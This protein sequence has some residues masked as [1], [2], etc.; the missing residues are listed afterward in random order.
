M[1]RRIE[2]D[3]IRTVV[4]FNL[5]PFHAAFLITATPGFSQ[6]PETSNVAKILL[7]YL[8]LIAP[9]HMPLLFIIAGYSLTASVEKRSSL[10]SHLYE[11]IQRLLVPLLVFMTIF[12]PLIVY[13][14]PIYQGERSFSHYFFKFWP[15]ILSRLFYNEFTEGPGWAHLW[16]VGYLMLMTLIILPALHYRNSERVKHLSSLITNLLCSP[17]GMFFPALLFGFCFM[18]LALIWP[19]YQVNLYSDWAYFC[20]NFIAFFIGCFMFGKEKFLDLIEKYRFLWLFLFLVST[21]AKLNFASFADSYIPERTSPELSFIYSIYSFSSGINVWSWI[22]LILGFAKRNL[23]FS[24]QFIKYTVKS[25]YT[26]YILHFVI[27]VVV[28]YFVTQWGLGVFL[29]FLVLSSITLIVTAIIYEFFV[30]RWPLTRWMF[31]IK[32]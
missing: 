7:F 28:G 10:I 8:W 13:Y 15:Y 16:F 11:R 18:P 20:Y 6:I 2:F 14:W 3:W 22:L 4:I 19:F 26:Y 25:S 12:N 29:E 30:R 24:N 1:V 32:G 9:L 5:F 31:G 21:I 27:M 23:N 17:V